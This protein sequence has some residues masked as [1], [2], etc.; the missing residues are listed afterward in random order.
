MFSYEGQTNNLKVVS[1]GSG[2]LDEMIQELNEGMIM[3]AF[4][5]VIDEK[6]TLPKCL[7]VNW[8]CS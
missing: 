8:V 4:C 6:T 2:G 7:L 3:Y 1:S 5:R